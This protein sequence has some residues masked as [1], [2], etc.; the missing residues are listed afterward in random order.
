[1]SI[2]ISTKAEIVGPW[3]ARKIFGPWNN[4]PAIGLERNG[5]M[6]AGVIY[7][8]WNRKSVTCHI[9]VEGLM[10]P[11]YLAAIFH[12]PFVFLGCE[13]IIA[14]ISEGNEESIRLVKKM[15]F[16]REA[17]LKDSHPD[18]DLYLYT[19]KRQDCRFTGERYVRKQPHCKF[20]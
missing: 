9:A 6:V 4:S 5:V 17:T 11:A 13:K 3:V 19:M 8:N 1:M 2:A 12:Y 16:E 7:E 20:A 18:G 15:G 14:P 10:T